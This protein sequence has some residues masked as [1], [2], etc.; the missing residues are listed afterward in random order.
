MG[1]TG[2]SEVVTCDLRP[3]I[4]IHV[5]KIWGKDI[6]G[7]KNQKCQGPEQEEQA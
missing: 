6:L 5:K 7:W 2:F 1:W 4:A 3:E